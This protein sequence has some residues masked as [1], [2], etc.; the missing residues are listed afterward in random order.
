MLSADPLW[1]KD[2]VFYEI[3][4]KAFADGNGDGI[5]DFQG[6]IG[7]LDYLQWLGVDCLW[8]LPFYPSPLKDDGYD[9]ADFLSVAEQYG[10]NE[11]VRRFLDDAHARGIRVIVDL[12]L[13]HTSD[14][15]PWF[16]DARRSPESPTH[17]FYVWSDTDR[18][19]EKARIIF[20][21]TEKSNWTWEPEA[22]RFYWHRFFSHQPD[23]NYE[24]PEVRRAM[25]DTMLY[26]LDQ[27]L[28]G[29][30]CDAVPY[31]FEREGTICENL[32]ETH[33]Y[34]KDIRRRIDASYQG[35]ILLAEANQWPSDV[36]PYFGEGDEFHMAFHFP[37]MPR[38]YMGMRSETRDPII[39]MFTH[40]PEIPP[41]CQWGLFLRNHDELTL[42]M[43]S[44]EERDYMYYTFASDPKM[45]RNIGI[46]R[47]LSP[48]LDNDRRKIELLNSLVFTMPGSPIIY[49]GDEIGMGDNIQ[50]KDRDGV[51]TPMQWTM[52]R[53]GGF[54]TCDPTLLYL[55]VVA[56]PVYGYQSI[57]VESQKELP[58]SL[59][60]WMKRVIMVRKRHAAF[61]RGTITFLRPANGK[62]LPYLRRYEG[63]V[64]LCVHN[65]A[66]SAQSVELD[67]KEFAGSVPLELLGESRFPP[68]TERPYVLTLAP[69]G[70]YWLDLMPEPAGLE[71]YGIEQSLL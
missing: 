54:S 24:N 36:R 58:H 67:L 42:E 25:V 31:L 68:V 53:N 8:L 23:L 49:Y 66:G 12:V 1:Y 30:R 47:R 17:G 18:K 64:L 4:V 57:N 27:G 50:L 28:D 19:Y 13:N 26:W 5:G 20:I 41:N 10:T 44:G 40:T 69:Y 33:E 46:G 62:V 45:R 14:Q 39:D 65:L 70:Y 22:K 56:D 55:P 48:L 32:P 3:P 71:T 61:G 21:D 38:L 9:V 51:R 34:L 2:A 63:A 59:L 6:L 37:L 35:R 60:H 29:F 43:C 15:H 52:D 16:Q 11:D 7:K